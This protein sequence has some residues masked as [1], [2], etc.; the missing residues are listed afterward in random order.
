MY[1]HPK[2]P[3]LVTNMDNKQFKS[4]TKKELI[5]ALADTPEN[6]E[7]LVIIHA[8]E[9]L[10]RTVKRARTANGKDGVFGVIEV[11]KKL[12]H[13]KEINLIPLD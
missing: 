2:L 12:K 1:N 11:F 7:V 8:S 10:R 9:P 5:E 6:A 13:E 4:M 3:N